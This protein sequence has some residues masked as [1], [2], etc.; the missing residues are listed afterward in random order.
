MVERNVVV[1]IPCGLHIRPAALLSG[2]AAKYR[3]TSQIV[4]KYHIINTFSILNIVASGIRCGD[5]VCVRCNGVDEE[6]ALASLTAI[7]QDTTISS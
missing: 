1:L 3:A 7:L 4:F 6:E 5:E 2:E